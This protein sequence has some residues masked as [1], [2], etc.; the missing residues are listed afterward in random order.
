L[1][2]A[3]VVPAAAA[4]KATLLCVNVGSG[5]GTGRG[6][7]RVDPTS[8]L[9]PNALAIH[10]PHHLAA[11][12]T[13]RGEVVMATAFVL[14][15]LCAQ[16]PTVTVDAV[17]GGR[18]W[19]IDTAQG[20]VHVWQPD[21]LPTGRCGTVLYVHG[22]FS[23][24][25]EV[26][27][28]H[29][30]AAQFSQSQVQA[31]FIVPEVPQNRRQPERWPQLAALLDLVA[32]KIGD[33][34]RGGPL[35]AIGHSGAYRTIA[36]WLDEGLLADIVLLDALYGREEQYASW[37]GA[38]DQRHRLVLASDLTR[39]RSD[40]L[41]GRFAQALRRR[42]IEPPTTTAERSAQLVY[43]ADRYGHLE[44]VTDGVAIPTLLAWTV[45]EP[46]RAP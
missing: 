19:R 45:L 43:F 23:D 12:S 26:W 40:R 37:L 3:I 29:Q 28:Q 46:G 39:R 9:R 13:P 33:A 11:A 38:T 16:V 30:L 4:G 25:D 14:V 34:C 35:V 17:A 27:Q 44:L 32:S 7:E 1:T 10:L 24:V 36:A 42:E 41:V 31:R 18:H 8:V 5:G 20:G 6:A 22:Y 21:G 15:L 2:G